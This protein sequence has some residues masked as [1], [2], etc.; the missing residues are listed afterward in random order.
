MIPKVG[1]LVACWVGSW[2]YGG[3]GGRLLGSTFGWVV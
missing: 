3:G 1:K 2:F